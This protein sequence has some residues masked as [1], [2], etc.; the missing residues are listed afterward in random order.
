MRF[1]VGITGASGVL[2]GY[3]F[4]QAL[5]AHEDI[6]IHLVISDAAKTNFRYE[7]TILPEQVEALA[8]HVW[9]DN[10]MAASISSGS[11]ETE[12]MVIVPCSMKTLSN[13]ATGNACTLI[14]RAADVC[15]KEGRTVILVPRETPLSK[16]HLRNM[17]TAAES[18]CTIIP[19]M[20]TFYNQAQTLDEQMDHIIGKILQQ[21]RM[22][23]TPFRP[24]QA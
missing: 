7:T 8:D 19:P 13:V 10:N 14:A 24:W 6:E 15:L 11:F 9:A 21:F 1:I 17:S 22:K 23:Y 16:I 18:G 12:G 4:M 20:L 5:R 3:R 2:L